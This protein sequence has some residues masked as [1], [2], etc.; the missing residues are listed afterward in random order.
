[1]KNMKKNYFITILCMC[2]GLFTNAQQDVFHKSDSGTGDWGS[3]NLPWY[4]GTSN[5]NQGD[6]DNGNNT[7]NFVKIGHNNDLTMTTNGR[8]Y[9]FASLDFQAGASSARTINNTGGGLSGSIGIYNLSSATHIFNT[10]IGID[11]ATV[12]LWA[13][14]TG[15][16]TFNDFIYI[17]ANTV[18]FGGTGTGNISVTGTMQGTGNVTKT[19]TNSLT[20]SGTNTYSGATTVSA[21]TLVLNS[22][23]ANSAFTVNSGIMNPS[24][25]LSLSLRV[26]YKFS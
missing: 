25:D 24:T 6:P 7:R 13:N 12:Q 2:M 9:I 15:G 11:A 16:F 20:I 4:Y 18:E 26:L 19:G 21:G 22:S 10:P 5:N 17:N 3:A 14:S 8:F 23:A 1:M